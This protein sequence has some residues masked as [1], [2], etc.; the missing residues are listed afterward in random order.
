TVMVL[1]SSSSLATLTLNPPMDPDISSRKG[2]LESN[3]IR[4]IRLIHRNP[5]RKNLIRGLVD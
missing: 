4:S 5:I 1:S 3:L 2:C